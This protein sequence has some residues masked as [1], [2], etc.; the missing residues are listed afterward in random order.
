MAFKGGYRFKRFEGIAEPVLRDLAVP[1]KAVIPLEDGWSL[2]DQ[3]AERASVK[4]GD[5]IA[6]TP[7]GSVAALAPINGDIESIGDGRLVIAGDGSSSFLPVPGHTRAPWRLSQAEAA[8]VL[9]LAGIEQFWG[10]L[11]EARCTRI[12]HIII[13]AVFNSPLNQAWSPELMTDQAL[14]PAGL[15][16]LKVVFPNAAIIIA[17]NKRNAAYFQTAEIRET[18][19]IKILSDKYPQEHPVLLA[20]DAAGVSL[21]SNDGQYDP[22]IH[23][24]SFFDVVQVAGALTQGHPLIDRIV[25]VAGPGV[26]RPGWCRIR[27]GTP[28]DAIRGE[29]M[30]SDEMGPWRIVRGG[31]LTGDGVVSPYET[32][33]ARENEIAVI[34]EHAVRELWRFMMP[35]FTW[36]CYPNIAAADFIPIVDKRLDTSVHGGK[37]PCVQCNYCDEVCPVDIYPFLIWKHVQADK[38]AESYRLRPELCIGCGLCDYV[39][40]SRID[41]SQSVTAVAREVF[42][43]RRKVHEGD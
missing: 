7:D 13:N 28:I 36:D 16:C 24:L 15:K 3:V 42:E 31:L 29:M 39:C 18:A 19:E 23:I 34:R 12:S 22:S 2:S 14:F 25:M 8:E 11:T 38:T 32:L 30:K 1:Q 9:R 10:A 43:A 37:R 41:I 26:S 17:V 6:V 4:A 35:G 21:V 27:I 33:H 20:R 5:T 40:P